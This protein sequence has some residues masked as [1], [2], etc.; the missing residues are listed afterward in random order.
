MGNIALFSNEI[1]IYLPLQAKEKHLYADD[2]R[3]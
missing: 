2:S 1:N 3:I